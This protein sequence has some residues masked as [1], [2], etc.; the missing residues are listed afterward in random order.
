M[1]S[2]GEEFREHVGRPCAQPGS[3]RFPKLEDLD[4]EAGRFRYDEAYE[5]KRPDW[6]YEEG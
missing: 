4:E 5:R 2:F 3:V 6:T 1:H